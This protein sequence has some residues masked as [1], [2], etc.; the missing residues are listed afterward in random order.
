VVNGRDSE[1]AAEAAGR[2]KGAVAHPGS[3][4]DP[5]TA[6]ALIDRCISEFGRI[7]ILVNCAGTA[8][9]ASESILSPAHS[10]TT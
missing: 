2:I 4:A 5:K 10:S 6:D 7:D 3:P 9:L 8:G 1:A